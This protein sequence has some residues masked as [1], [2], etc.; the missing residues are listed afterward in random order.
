MRYDWVRRVRRVRLGTAG[1]RVRLGTAG[2]AL[3]LASSVALAQQQTPV[4]RGGITIVPLTVTVLDKN[5]KPV[6]DLTQSDFTIFEDG[7]KQEI[8]TF[9]A[10][11]LTPQPPPAHEPPTLVRPTRFADATPATRR[12]FLLVL[13]FGRIQVPA[14]GLDGA[15]Q[16]VQERLL[17]QDYVAV[18]GFDR[19]TDFTT[20]HAQVARVIERYKAKH[21]EILSAIALFYSWPGNR[22]KPLPDAIQADIDA[23]FQTRPH[24]PSSMRSASSL[25]LGSETF[26]RDAQKAEIRRQNSYGA[27][28]QPD[29]NPMDVQII[30]GDLLKMHTGIEY[31]RYLD[32]DKHLIW[33]VDH[34]L[35][36]TLAGVPRS[37]QDD[38][39]LASRANDAGVVTDI[40]HTGGVPVPG[41]GGRV[42]LNTLDVVQS[43]ETI[44][45]FSGGQF[46]GVSYAKDVLARIDDATRFNYVLGYKPAKSDLDGRFR[47]I[48][49]KVNRP[50]VTV[51][52]RHGYNADVEPPPLDLRTLLTASRLTAA[53]MGETAG[54]D[55]KITANASVVAAVGGRRFVVDMTIDASRVRFTTDGDRH[56]VA[57]EIRVFCG[58]KDEKT[59]GDY[60]DSLDLSL[61][62][63]EYQRTLA[64]GIRY[65][66]RGPITGDIKYAKVI[67]YDYRADLLGT[68]TIKLK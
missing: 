44:A 14:K 40:I 9:A 47:K 68:A 58:D 28:T 32:G 54:N 8:K 36:G 4:F 45:E 42:P 53:G 7:A 60:S 55:I 23:V 64:S 2:T 18:L 37:V 63:A 29:P 46:S 35:S 16:F 43:S 21:E 62:E 50:G 39:E 41:R 24:D 13:G 52:F 30:F 20:D 6:T 5:G 66:A 49:V 34:G 15:L 61:S 1:T 25:L 51:L 65:T 11:A 59:I 33:I 38:E 19:A 10:E 31:L 48:N 26:Q 22:G 56:V 3:A 17:P 67:V 57:L 12:T 27:P